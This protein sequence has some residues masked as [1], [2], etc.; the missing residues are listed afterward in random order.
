VELPSDL[1]IVDHH[2]HLS[3]NGE[4]IGAARRFEA[5]GG[6]H[7]FLA[8]QNYAP[9]VPFELSG[10]REQFETTE[11]L[12]HR[13]AAE[14]RVQVYVVVAP[15]PIDLLAQAERLGSAAAVALQTAALDL[16]GQWV[17]EHRAV[18][19]GEVGRPHFHIPPELSESVE[20][21][22]LYAL[23]VAREAACPAVVHCG[24]LD[25][26]GYRELA[27]T[28]ARA[29]FPVQ[30]LV[31]HYARAVVP[32]QERCGLVPS[33]IARK[34]LIDPIQS[35]PGPWFLETDFLDD[36][37]RK[38]AVLD[39]TTVPKRARAIAARGP[40]GLERLRIPFVDSVRS[41]Y[42]FTP[43]ARAREVV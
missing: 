10:Y 20:E 31:K 30:K 15:Y 29:S 34:E 33:Y 2:A 22:F 36:P 5:A 32:L 17:A 14:T 39:V 18:A 12:A 4:G 7:L 41:V 35:D 3:P 24:D 28:A 26:P 21:V 9:Q 40:E 11:H 1:P 27:E 42:G 13:I 16:A 37:A 25:A 43:L 6:T 23:G 8:T 19:L 38:G